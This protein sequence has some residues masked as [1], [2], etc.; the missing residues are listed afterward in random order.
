MTVY[1]VGTLNAQYVYEWK[2]GS[3]SLEHSIQKLLVTSFSLCS[4]LRRCAFME[5]I[6]A[7]EF[8]LKLSIQSSLSLSLLFCVALGPLCSSNFHDLSFKTSVFLPSSL[9][10]NVPRCLVFDLSLLFLPWT[11]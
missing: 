11:L 2:I 4:V 8:S 3:M 9:S 7:F 5:G 1:P 6:K 10:C